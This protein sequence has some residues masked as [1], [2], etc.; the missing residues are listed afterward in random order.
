MHHKF[1]NYN[2]DMDE[3]TL[4]MLTALTDACEGH[5]VLNYA[6]IESSTSDENLNITIK[7]QDGRILQ[8]EQVDIKALNDAVQH[9]KEEHPGFFQRILGAMM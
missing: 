5:L 4:N 9:W 1:N 3:I 2:T 8:P 6:G 7:M